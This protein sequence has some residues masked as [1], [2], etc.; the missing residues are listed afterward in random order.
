LLTTAGKLLFDGDLGG[1][2]WS[3]THARS[4]ES[5]GPWPN[6]SGLFSILVVTR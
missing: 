3:R 6:G 5:P 2:L 4:G 1:R